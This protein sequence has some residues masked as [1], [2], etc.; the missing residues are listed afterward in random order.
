MSHLCWHLIHGQ[1]D[2]KTSRYIVVHIW[3]AH[4]RGTSKQLTPQSTAI[5]K[6]KDKIKG[7]EQSPSSRTY[8]TL[9]LYRSET[10]GW[11]TLAGFLNR[12]WQFTVIEIVHIFA[13]K[14]SEGKRNGVGCVCVRSVGGEFKSTPLCTKGRNQSTAHNSGAGHKSFAREK[15]RRWKPIQTDKKK[16]LA[17]HLPTTKRLGEDFYL[18]RDF[19]FYDSFIKSVDDLFAHLNV[20]SLKLC[21]RTL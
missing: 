14:P 8:I 17:L 7:S 4:G 11:T 9:H 16:A 19:F 18:L 12:W 1:T 5:T 3:H 15:K 2:T 10:V 13:R 20:E 21:R 6:I